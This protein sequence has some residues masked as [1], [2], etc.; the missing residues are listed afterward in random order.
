MST[1]RQCV[2]VSVHLF[3]ILDIFLYHHVWV[4]QLLFFCRLMWRVMS[5]HVE[6]IGSFHHVSPVHR[7]GTVFETTRS[8][9]V[10]QSGS[11]LESLLS[12]RHL[13]APM[14]W[15]MEHHLT[16]GTIWN[17]MEPH[18]I[19]DTALDITWNTMQFEVWSILTTS[20]P[21]VRWSKMM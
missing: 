20:A 1:F 15:T 7:S 4:Q 12:G 13:V 5:N 19:I 3:D 9:L 8:T 16:H 18:G 17:L 21:E 2:C 11:F 10:Q 6:P 14:T